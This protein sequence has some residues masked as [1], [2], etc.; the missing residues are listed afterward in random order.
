MKRLKNLLLR[1]WHSETGVAAVEYAMIAP[2][3]FFI[4][5]GVTDYGMYP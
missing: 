3:L 2:F 5:I 4:M 1:L